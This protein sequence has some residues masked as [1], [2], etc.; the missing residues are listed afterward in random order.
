M[1]IKIHTS[2]LIKPWPSSLFFLPWQ[3]LGYWLIKYIFRRHSFSWSALTQSVKNGPPNP[4]LFCHVGCWYIS[5]WCISDWFVIIWSFLFVY[6][7][8]WF[9]FCQNFL[10]FE[11]LLLMIFKNKENTV[12][13]YNI[14]LSARLTKYV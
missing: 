4:N 5:C 1:H 6:C 2:I 13:Y 7:N 10:F 9:K 11:L 8:F 3:D 12:G 14:K